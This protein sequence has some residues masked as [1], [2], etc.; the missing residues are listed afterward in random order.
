MADGDS[1]IARGR[2]EH[3][4]R[5]QTSRVANGV[6]SRF[7]S[8]E[9][10]LAGHPSVAG[11]RLGNLPRQGEKLAGDEWNGNRR[12]AEIAECGVAT[13]GGRGRAAESRPCRHAVRPAIDADR[14]ASREPTRRGRVVTAHDELRSAAGASSDF[15]GERCNGSTKRRIERGVRVDE[16][17]GATEEARENDGREV[18]I[19]LDRNP[20]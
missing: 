18:G 1:A 15:D 20:N 12:L 11:R 13:A 19:R 8:R 4:A 3:G 5:E 14:R 16:T 2:R 7:C 17:Y 10:S 6:R 9:P